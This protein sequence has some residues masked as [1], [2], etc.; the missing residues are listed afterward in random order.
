MHHLNSPHCRLNHGDRAPQIVSVHPAEAGWRLRTV[1]LDI[2]GS[3]NL[4][5]EDHEM[6]WA[7][8]TYCTR[9]GADE[10]SHGVNGH[11]DVMHAYYDPRPESPRDPGGFVTVLEVYTDAHPLC[12][13]HVTPPGV[14]L[15]DAQ[16]IRDLATRLGTRS[17][18]QPFEADFVARILDEEKARIEDLF[19]RPLYSEKGVQS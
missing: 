7:S 10:A 12:A 19:A 14:R 16:L 13:V 9:D 18:L 6:F 15:D 5:F 2:G 4:V 1:H 11:R 17:D 8:V 3:G